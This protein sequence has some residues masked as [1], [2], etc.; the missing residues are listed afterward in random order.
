M[1]AVRLQIDTREGVGLIEIALRVDDRARRIPVAGS[2][3]HRTTHGGVG[4]ALIVVT[5]ID[6]E[7]DAPQPCAHAGHDGNLDVGGAT[8]RVRG[9]R[10]ERFR[11]RPPLVAQP[12]HERVSPR[13]QRTPVKHTANR[14][15]KVP[16]RL[17]HIGVVGSTAVEAAQGE[18]ADPHRLPFHD[19]EGDLDHARPHRRNDGIDLHIGKAA[20]TVERLDAL[21][22]ARKLHGIE[23]TS[24]TD[25]RQPRERRG[26][27]GHG[28][29]QHDVGVLAISGES[30][31]TDLAVATI[32]G[33][34]LGG[35]RTRDRNDCEREEEMD[36]RS[37]V[38]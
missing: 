22:V 17:T 33:K 24:L 2:E 38:L 29:A 23:A 10:H 3:R 16:C 34:I 25:D 11:L 9:V 15:R 37:H 27:G 12:S 19:G 26:R 4:D 21:H 5:R 31:R 30:E 7:R 32:T 20:P 8:R 18:R 1:Y 14:Q 13:F 6:L 28:G 36:E 35:G